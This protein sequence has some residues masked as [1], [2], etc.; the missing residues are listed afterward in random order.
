MSV[1][2]TQQIKEE[3]DKNEIMY[4]MSDIPIKIGPDIYMFHAVPRSESCK[5]KGQCRHFPYY[6]HTGRTK[7]SIMYARAM[8]D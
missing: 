4:D 2:L 3:C 1:T 7:V 5:S 8:C 6:A